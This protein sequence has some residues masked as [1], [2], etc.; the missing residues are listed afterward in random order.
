MAATT[1]GRNAFDVAAPA[2]TNAT[3][4]PSSAPT[5]NSWTSCA[6]PRNGTWRP[7]LLALASGTNRS[8]GNDRSSRMRVISRPTAPVAPMTATSMRQGYQ[9]PRR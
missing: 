6:S 5:D 9:R 4:T 7:A 3:S 1:S 8:T 2:E